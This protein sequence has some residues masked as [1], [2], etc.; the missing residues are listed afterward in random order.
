MKHGQVLIKT[1]YNKPAN[2]KYLLFADNNNDPMRLQYELVFV[3][4]NET[5]EYSIESIDELTEQAK[6]IVEDA[7]LDF[8]NEMVL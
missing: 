8:S 3:T 7:Y 1:S 4:E 5:K 2:V 6:Y